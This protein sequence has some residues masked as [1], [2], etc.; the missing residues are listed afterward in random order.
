MV[1]LETAQHLLAFQEGILVST[2]MYQRG[3][4]NYTGSDWLFHKQDLCKKT[5]I[6]I[7]V[8]AMSFP[9]ESFT[10]S[11][12]MNQYLDRITRG[13]GVFLLL[14]SVH[15]GV[16]FSHVFVWVVC[17]RTPQVTHKQIGVAQLS[18]SLSYLHQHVI[19]SQ[20]E[21]SKA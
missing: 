2:C 21:N 19:Q 3:C 7:T 14:R 16:T 15:K 13:L 6:T 10:E 12:A 5:L 17:E 11:T 20:N 9:L 8:C 4:V 1:I 18:G